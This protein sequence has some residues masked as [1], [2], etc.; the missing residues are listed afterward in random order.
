MVQIFHS[1]GQFTGLPHEDP[2]IHVKTFIDIYDTY[3]P[4]GVSSDYVRLELFPYSLLGAAR[5]WLDSKPPNSITTWDCL[6]K[7]FLSR[8]FPSKKTAKLRGEIIYFIQKQGEDMY[9]AWA[10][11]KQKCNACPHHMQTNEVL[12]HTFF[13]GLDYDAHALLNSAAGNQGYEGEMSR[14]TTQKVAGILDVDQA[15]A[16]NAKL[17]AMQHNMALHFKQMSLNQAPINIVQ[18]AANWCEVCGSGT[19]ATKQCEANPDSVNYVENSQRGG[20]QQNY[21][22]AYNPSWRNHPNF[23]WDGNQNQN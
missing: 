22:N 8:F 15:T 5:H 7:K 21:G 9:Q 23:S 14:T 12:S 13:E 20:V 17:D 19:H 10:R 6:A 18:Q 2:Q 11:F 3:I 1:N 16:I 4:I